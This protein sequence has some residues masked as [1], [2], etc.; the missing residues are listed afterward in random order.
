MPRKVLDAEVGRVA[1]LG[2]DVVLAALREVTSGQVFDLDAGRF[3][4]MPQWD[5]HPVFSL[6]SF[7]TPHGSRHD[8][9]IDLLNPSRNKV[10]LRFHTELMITGMHIGTHIDALNHVA[11]GTQGDRFFGG[12]G[13]EDV[14]DFGPQRADAASIPPIIVRAAVLD[15]A[16]LHRLERLPAGSAISVADLLRAE[17]EQARI[18]NGGAVLLRTG[19][20][21]TW[22][23]SAA[24]AAAE[25]AGIDLDA[26]LWLARERNVVLV[27][28]DTPTVEQVPSTDH[29]NPHPV[30]DL[31]LRQVGIHLLENA[32]LE[33]LALRHE[34]SVT[35]VVL[36][37]KVEGAT[38]SMV[39]PIALI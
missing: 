31:L 13:P 7:R 29:T 2:P 30:H 20:M 17:A 34:H 1:R 36:P 8:G 26:A 18:P 32:W 6:T 10:D 15:I 9:D 5:G 3:V 35:L 19:L 11:S 37:L 21:K 38:A 33:D 39:R 25:G 22:P 16:S 4:G 28:A 12:F 24:F 27:G 23:D 14:G